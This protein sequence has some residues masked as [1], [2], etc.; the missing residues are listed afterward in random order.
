MTTEDHYH[1]TCAVADQIGLG[2]PINENLRA[3]HVVSNVLQKYKS[4]LQTAKLLWNKLKAPF[5]EDVDFPTSLPGRILGH[6]DEI[7]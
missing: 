1:D 4:H 2:V 6:K 5:E 7:E 3:V